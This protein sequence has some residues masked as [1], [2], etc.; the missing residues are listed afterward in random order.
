MVD[1][2]RR[3]IKVQSVCSLEESTFDKKRETTKRA[4]G[5]RRAL[6]GV[7]PKDGATLVSQKRATKATGPPKK[8]SQKMTTI[9]NHR[10]LQSRPKNKFN[11]TRHK[12]Q[13]QQQRRTHQHRA[14]ANR[15]CHDDASRI[16]SHARTST[17]TTL[18]L[19]VVQCF[20]AC[21]QRAGSLT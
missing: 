20:C 2:R 7:D 4:R 6:L 8:K 3:V 10:S 14:S 18:L 12:Q 16:S 5:E 15:T 19:R 9:Q 11:R 17:R 13:Q 1:R 21:H